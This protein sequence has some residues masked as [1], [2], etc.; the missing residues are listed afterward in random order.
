MNFIHSKRFPVIFAL[1]ALLATPLAVLA[2]EFFER[3]G[4][5]IAGYDPVAYF[6]ENRA[7]KG[8]AAHTYRYKDSVFRFAS[9][10]NRDAFAADPERYAP[11]YGGFCAY[12]VAHGYKVKIE[13]EGFTIVNG[14]LYLNYDLKVQDDWRK[15]VPGFIRKADERWPALARKR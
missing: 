14:R 6:T 1:V 12:G 9:A 11:R 3:D 10:A 7:V 2:G 13:P 5:A 8:S 4:A 15:D